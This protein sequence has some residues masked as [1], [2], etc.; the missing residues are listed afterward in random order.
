MFVHFQ[1]RIKTGSVS[2]EDSQHFKDWELTVLQKFKKDEPED[3]CDNEERKFIEAEDYLEDDTYYDDEYDEEM[4][5]SSARKVKNETDSKGKGKKKKKYMKDGKSCEPCDFVTTSQ[6]KYDRHN[7]E[8]HGQ[9]MC[10]ICGES[11][12]DFDKFFKHR[13]THEE[14]FEESPSKGKQE[15]EKKMCP[16]CGVVCKHLWVHI[17]YVHDKHK[18]TKCP[19]CDYVGQHMR[20]HMKSKH[21]EVN[22][23]NCPW[24]GRFTKNL[25]RHLRE[26]QCNV[27]EHERVV[28]PASVCEYCKKEFR[29]KKTLKEHIRNMH[30]NK[31]DVHCDRCGF[32]TKH[33]HNLFMHIK[34][35]HEGKPSK[36]LCPK[37]NKSCVNLEWH[38]ETYHPAGESAQTQGTVTC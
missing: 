13:L 30:S 22:A 10:S 19:H 9:N 12:D 29:T 31:E 17:R 2:W 27:P 5:F 26:N 20:A 8:Q 21:T 24:C 18:L 35:V 34:R 4:N 33:K 32:K 36:E 38:M 23:V 6:R 14:N 11:F 16:H 3:D 1:D 25:N 28:K 7:F 15:P 37:C